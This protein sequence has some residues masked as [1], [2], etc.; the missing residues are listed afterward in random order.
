MW[1]LPLLYM[2]VR[3]LKLLK[4]AIHGVFSLKQWNKHPSQFKKKKEWC[5]RD[6]LAPDLR[7]KALRLWSPNKMLPEGFT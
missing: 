7:G 2:W 3:P 5:G 6:I 4:A 1:G